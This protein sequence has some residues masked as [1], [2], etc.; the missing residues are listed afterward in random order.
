[1]IGVVAASGT[2]NQLCAAK[3]IRRDQ[4][5]G[6]Y[7]GACRASQ[8]GVA[9]P[10]EKRSTGLSVGPWANRADLLGKKG[11]GSRHQEEPGQG[12]AEESLH[13]KTILSIAA[14]FE[15]WLDRC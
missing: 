5:S 14:G 12:S 6:P 4:Q 9:V 2:R 15:G 7:E 11:A 8:K 3:R 1:M 10:D 13:S